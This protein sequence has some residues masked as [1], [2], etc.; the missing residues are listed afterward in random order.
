MTVS[1]H[2]LQKKNAFAH[3]M[4]AQAISHATTHGHLILKIALALPTD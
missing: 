4:N 3:A 2:N 1:L